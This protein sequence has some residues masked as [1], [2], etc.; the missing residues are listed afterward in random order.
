MSKNLLWLELGTTFFGKQG[1]PWQGGALLSGSR[2][3]GL[4]FSWPNPKNLPRFYM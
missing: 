1:A 4:L 3:V 2:Q